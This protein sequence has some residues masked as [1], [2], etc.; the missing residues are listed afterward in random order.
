MSTNQVNYGV[1]TESVLPIRLYDYEKIYGSASGLVFPLYYKIPDENTGT[2]KDQGHWQTCA[3]CT[4]AAVAEGIYRV[5]TGET[6]DTEMSE[7]FVYGSFRDDSSTCSGM[8]LSIA[9]NYWAKIGMVKKSYFDIVTEM[10]E[11]KEI[12]K[13]YPELIEIASKIKI[14]GYCAINYADRDKRDTCIK[15]ALMENQYGIVAVSKHAF[16]NPHCFQIVGWD[17]KKDKYLFKNSYGE[18]YGE[19]GFFAISKD[20]INEAYVIISKPIELPFEDVDK[21]HWAYKYIKNMYLNGIMSGTGS[22]TF[23][24]NKPLTRAEAAT[25]FYRVIK[26]I[27]ERF[28]ILNNVINDKLDLAKSRKEL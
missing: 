5:T 18:A 8:T 27:D 28:S 2:L 20:S 25:L 21:N 7:G 22:N 16:G 6:S 23:E 3:A 11:L 15:K 19:K 17:D 26:T 14:D 10:P 4:I 9:L 13:K 12:I 24:P 1:N